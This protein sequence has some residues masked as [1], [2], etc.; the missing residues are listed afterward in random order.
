MRNNIFKRTVYKILTHW[1]PPTHNSCRQSNLEWGGE[2][3]PRDK[4]YVLP[5]D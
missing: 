1:K 2:I 3:K 4:T 5:S